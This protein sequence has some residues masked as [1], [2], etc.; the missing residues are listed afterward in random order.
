MTGL[1]YCTGFESWIGVLVSSCDSNN[2][3]LESACKWVTILWSHES[4]A[5]IGVTVK[6][7]GCWMTAMDPFPRSLTVVFCLV[8]ELRLLSRG[9]TQFLSAVD[10]AA[11]T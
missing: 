7:P 4:A 3:V 2:F 11:C 8:C 5:P 6:D 9:Y 1:M 10:R